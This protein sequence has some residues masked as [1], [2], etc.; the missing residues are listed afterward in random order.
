MSPEREPLG[1]AGCTINVN[2]LTALILVCR[3]FE[4]TGVSERMPVRCRKFLTRHFYHPHSCYFGFSTQTQTEITVSKTLV[5]K[6]LG[7]IS[8][9]IDNSIKAQLLLRLQMSRAVQ[10]LYPRGN[11]GTKKLL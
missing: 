9:S 7:L 2:R 11:S 10:L 1:E 4:G 5:P 3:E 6:N 8:K